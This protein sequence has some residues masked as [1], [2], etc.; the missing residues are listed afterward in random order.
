MSLHPI[1]IQVLAPFAPPPRR[2]TYAH[3]FKRAAGYEL[4]ITET[5]NLGTTI[6]IERC[7]NKLQARAIADR[8]GAKPWNF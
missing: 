5:P 3:A 1:F 2:V 6:R 7:A 4:H 8:L